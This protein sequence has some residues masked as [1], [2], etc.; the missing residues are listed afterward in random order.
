[1]LV[2]WLKQD[3]ADIVTMPLG[4]TVDILRGM[5]S[6][7]QVLETLGGLVDQMRDSSPA[8]RI[9]VIAQYFPPLAMDRHVR[10][11]NPAIPAYFAHKNLTASPVWVVDQW[12]NFTSA[13]PYDGIHPSASGDVKVA[14]RFYP[15]LVQAIQ[16]IRRIRQK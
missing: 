10:G 7:P 5:R 14:I 11:L 3:L 16:S 15:A 8:V 9:I 1:M 2:D 13:D 6:P 4:G 12:T